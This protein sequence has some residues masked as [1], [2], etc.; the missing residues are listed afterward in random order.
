M[1][2]PQN[3]IY[4]SYGEYYCQPCIIE[5]LSDD[6]PIYPVTN[7]ICPPKTVLFPNNKCY[8]VN[9]V[10]TGI[11]KPID[12]NCSGPRVLFSD[13]KC[14]NVSRYGPGLNRL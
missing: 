9:T 11:L 1:P 2:L 4:S 12:S 3:C 10:D 6:N 8:S 7:S 5:N 14:Y 13:N